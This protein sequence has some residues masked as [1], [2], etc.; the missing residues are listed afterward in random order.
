M[1]DAK[2]AGGK[3]SWSAPVEPGGPRNQPPV[4]PKGQID[5]RNGHRPSALTLPLKRRDL[6]HVPLAAP[7]KNYT[8]IRRAS[9][10][11]ARNWPSPSYPKVSVEP[12][13]EGQV[14]PLPEADRPSAAAR[15]DG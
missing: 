6:R 1:P 7:H 13:S 4:P 3:V 5:V 15:H 8:N 2:T 9:G 11:F 12:L 10:M 14:S